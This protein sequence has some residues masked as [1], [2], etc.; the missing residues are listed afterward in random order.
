MFGIGISGTSDDDSGT[1]A[2]DDAEASNRPNARQ[3]AATGASAK[4]VAFAGAF[5]L[6]SSGR[7]ARFRTGGGSRYS[8]GLALGGAR[9]SPHAFAE[10]KAWRARRSA[11]SM[12]WSWWNLGSARCRVIRPWRLARNI[13]SDYLGSLAAAIDA[14][15]TL[16]AQSP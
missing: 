12:V 10:Q 4:K 15:A 9:R 14:A 5:E 16:N 8:P 11:R 6:A 13:M 2:A 7:N 1:G 3:P